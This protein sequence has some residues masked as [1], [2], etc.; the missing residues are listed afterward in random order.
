[1]I[2]SVGIVR[3]SLDRLRE[4]GFQGPGEANGEAQAIFDQP[5]PFL[6]KVCQSAHLDALRL[7]RFKPFAMA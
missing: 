5:T 3:E 6:D 1:V 7:Q 2:G 4:I